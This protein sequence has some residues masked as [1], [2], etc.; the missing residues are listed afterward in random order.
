MSNAPNLVEQIIDDLWKKGPFVEVEFKAQAKAQLDAHY[1]QHT[2]RAVREARKPG[3]DPNL[4][5]SWVFIGDNARLKNLD[6]LYW[7]YIAEE[8]AQNNN[9]QPY[10]RKATPES[11][12]EYL[13]KNMKFAS[14]NQVGLWLGL[15]RADQHAK[16][17]LAQLQQ[18][19]K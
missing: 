7:S 9:H 8:M 16:A 6:D 19:V 11:E 17:R 4:L 14:F 2:A 1:S 3:Y 12:L 15:A 10:T 13:K 18:G 5:G